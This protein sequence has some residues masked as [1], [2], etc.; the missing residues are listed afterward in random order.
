MKASSCTVK[1]AVVVALFC[2]CGTAAAVD[3]KI[4]K[5]EYRVRSGRSVIIL[6]GEAKMPENSRI[7]L[8]LKNQDYQDSIIAFEAGMTIKNR[9]DFTWNT[10]KLLRPG[11]YTV[12]AAFRP[13]K[14]EIVE[15]A[16]IYQF[17]VGNEKEIADEYKKEK[18]ILS[19]HVETLW[20]LYNQL[21][22]FYES[23]LY[24]I[25]IEG[26]Y[27]RDAWDTWSGCWT[28]SVW[29]T[30]RSIISCIE[31]ATENRE[32]G[33]KALKLSYNILAFYCFCSTKLGAKP[34]LD[35][36]DLGADGTL[37][38]EEDIDVW[39]KAIEDSFSRMGIRKDQKG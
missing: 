14:E 21:V 20:S 29:K 1:C 31:T 37:E 2:I 15:F 13:V 19:R 33:D 28:E 12:L 22:E 39:K 34:I 24:Q 17:S 35:I 7:Y 27:D 26:A 30:G 25:K 11:H 10:K 36:H 5:A 3:F 16:T 4:T 32:A 18:E 38:Y 8:M 6:K 9:F 23:S